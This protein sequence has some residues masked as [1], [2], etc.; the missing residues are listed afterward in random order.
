M[1]YLRAMT[2]ITPAGAMLELPP[3]DTK[4]WVVRRKA[5][6]VRAVHIGRISLLE[7]CLR[8]N[9]SVEGF[10]AWERAVERHG[11]PAMRLYRD[12]EKPRG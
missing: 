1:A 3:S 8:Y 10:L 6:V 12:A 9:L 4:R 5:A 7:A 11:T 2:Q